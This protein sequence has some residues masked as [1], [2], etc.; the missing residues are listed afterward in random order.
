[1]A[2]KISF[3][4]TSR[5]SERR[6]PKRRQRPGD[7]ERAVSKIRANRKTAVCVRP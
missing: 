7:I 6:E 1:M 2:R 3:N 5:V 4:S